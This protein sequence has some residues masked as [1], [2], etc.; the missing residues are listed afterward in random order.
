MSGELQQSKGEELQPAPQVENPSKIANFKPTP[1]MRL[2]ADKMVELIEDGGCP[3]LPEAAVAAGLVRQCPHRWHKRYGTAFNAW[4]SQVLRSMSPAVHIRI[5]D[6]ALNC[7]HRGRAAAAKLYLQVME[8][9]SERTQVD[10][11]HGG[12]VELVPGENDVSHRIAA[13]RQLREQQAAQ[14]LEAEATV[15][16][17]P[18]GEVDNA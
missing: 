7:E 11:T 17:V 6:D 18:E 4:L 3:T 14:T 15:I 12:S 2:M 8:G 10:H 16:D 9:W 5:T 13:A 1:S